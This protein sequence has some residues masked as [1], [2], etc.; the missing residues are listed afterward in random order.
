MRSLEEYFRFTNL[1]RGGIGRVREW[2]SSVY[3][4]RVKKAAQEKTYEMPCEFDEWQLL[5]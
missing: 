1:D 5:S 4:E 3:S 2:D